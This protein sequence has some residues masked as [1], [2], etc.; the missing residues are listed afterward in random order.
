L[1]FPAKA[2]T[3]SH[4]SGIWVP[5]CAGTG[6]GATAGATEQGASRQPSGAWRPL[7][8]ASVRR[9]AGRSLSLERNLMISS[10]T[11]R[12]RP[13]ARTHEPLLERERVSWFFPR[14]RAV[15]RKTGSADPA[16]GLAGWRCTKSRR[17]A[18][19]LPSFEQRRKSSSARQCSSSWIDRR[20]HTV[21]EFGANTG[22]RLIFFGAPVPLPSLLARIVGPRPPS[23]NPLSDAQ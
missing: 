15:R 2:G 10:G 13:I 1:S 17:A 5:A 8:G 23:S 14:F 19:C 4:G 11:H 21:S 16:R 3:H 7:G 20:G 9:S 22:K 6:A 12:G 18:G